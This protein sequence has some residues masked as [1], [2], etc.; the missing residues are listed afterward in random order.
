MRLLCKV[1]VFFSNI[2]GD[3]E[4]AAKYK[5]VSSTQ[6]LLDQL[7]ASNHV[8]VSFTNPELKS[9]YQN[10]KECSESTFAPTPTNSSN[11]IP[12]DENCTQ[13]NSQGSSFMIFVPQEF[14]KDKTQIIR[15]LFIISE[16]SET[17]SSVSTSAASKSV[18]FSPQTSNNSNF[19][20]RLSSSNS[21]FDLTSEK[22]IHHC[23]NKLG[24]FANIGIVSEQQAQTENFPSSPFTISPITK[25]NG[26][27][28]YL[29]L[30]RGSTEV[31]SWDG[32][33]TFLYASMP[34]KRSLYQ[35]KNNCDM[36]K[37]VSLIL[38]TPKQK[39]LNEKKSEIKAKLKGGQ[40]LK[41]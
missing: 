23:I 32:P 8:L 12:T 10:N 35:H 26:Y 9:S 34:V 29:Q 14:S 15:L 6:E 37:S 7:K 33:S 24:R 31:F 3:L 21:F 36:Q 2:K 18:K 41:K 25:M 4:L 17:H 39:I 40:C 13:E 1:N 28:L 11:S 22:H 38:V 5:V 19:V 30:P 16:K 27:L 20:R